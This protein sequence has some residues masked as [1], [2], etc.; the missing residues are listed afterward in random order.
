MS[1]LRQ[2]LQLNYLLPILT[3]GIVHGILSVI[4]QMS[5][6]IM[7]FSGPASHYLSH[8]IGLILFGGMVVGLVT[9]LLSSFSGTVALSQEN[10]AAVASI[11]A[12]HLGVI[13]ATHATPEEI[14]LTI[15]VTIG[16]SSI[17]TGILFVMLGHFNLGI[18]VRFIPYPVIGGF[19]AGTGWLLF[20]GGIHVITD[21]PVSLSELSSLCQVDNLIKCLSGLVF[22]VL[23]VVAGRRSKHLLTMPFLLCIAVGVFYLVLWFTET[24]LAQARHHGWLLMPFPGHGFWQPLSSSD[25]AQ[26]NWLAIAG[27]ADHIGVI[28]LISTLNL[29]LNVSGM[30]LALKQE[31]DLNRE[32]QAAG[33]ANIVGG[34]S[35]GTVG[36]HSLSKS[37]L[38][39]KMNI[40]GR[41]IGLFSAFVVGLILFFGAPLVAYFPKPILGGLLLYLSLSF[42]LEWLYD[43]WFKLSK[44]EYL[45]IWLILVLIS[46][47]GILAGMCVGFIMA[48]ILFII[49]YSR[50]GIIKGVLSGTTY[51][52]NVERSIE[53]RHLLFKEGEQISILLLHGFI[54]FGTA[55]KLLNQ[56]RFRLGAT[57]LVALRYLIL[58]FRAVTGFDSSALHSFVKIRQLAVTKNFTLIL[59]HLSVPLQYQLGEEFYLEERDT[60]VKFFADLDDGVTWCE[61]QI[62]RSENALESETSTSL[63]MLLRVLIPEVNVSRLMHRL[64]QRKVGKDYH[65]M[66]QGEASQGMFFI[67]SGQVRAQIKT[68]TG[69]VT[70][71]RVLSAGSIVGDLGLY[72]GVPITATVIAEKPS[73][74]YHLSINALR[75]MEREDTELASAF[76]K[77][78]VRTLGER[79]M[80]MNKC[81]IQL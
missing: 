74:L 42:L 73:V 49:E 39:P 43:T 46:T 27:E 36:F 80:N 44:A 67:E 31:V 62:L 33:I 81:W 61:E 35:G 72:L 37:T 30:E 28:L 53:H 9:T 55:N 17:L 70:R 12:V 5:L 4:S 54:F 15:V 63:E 32:L 13:M 79:L 48:T 65:L 16:L 23:L 50:I 40:N 64:E 51:Q 45:L 47:V 11:M 68:V 1:H 71:I 66:R 78:I 69:E 25:F 52:S 6:A 24:S 38:G 41:L 75:Q 20:K 8:G 14:F 77:F 10:P 58:D 2:L 21:I 7:I 19:L 59:T 26:V 3:L 29:L 34:M 22:A 76:H 18:L 56:I 57:H 60:V